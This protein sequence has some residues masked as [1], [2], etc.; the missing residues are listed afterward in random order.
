MNCWERAIAAQI[1]PPR[2]VP[3]DPASAVL[4]GFGS[5]SGSR[6]GWRR[7]SGVASLTAVVGMMGREDLVYDGRSL[8]PDGGVTFSSATPDVTNLVLPRRPTSLGF[9]SNEN[10]PN[11]C[12]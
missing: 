2:T 7:A 12:V 6:R 3:L 8:V 4:E 5:G 9:F 1:D 11:S 10:E